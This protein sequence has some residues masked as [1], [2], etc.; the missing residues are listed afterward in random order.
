MSEKLLVLSM[1]ALVTEDLSYLQHKPNYKKLF[2]HAAS[3]GKIC[4]VYPSIT[5][6]AHTAII[7]GC[8]PGKHGV[9]DN[10]ELK[11]HGKPNGQWFIYADKIKTDDLF[12]AAKRAGKT[13][14]SVFWP[15]TGKH[16]AIDWLI[17]ECFPYWMPDVNPQEMFHRLGSS[18]AVIDII[19]RNLYRYPIQDRDISGLQ[20]WNTSDHFLTGCA[21][22]IIR[23]FQPDLLM[24][25]NCYPDSMRHR[26]GL[27]SPRTEEVLDQMDLWLGEL[28]DALEETGTYDQTNFVLVS[29]HGQ[30]DYAR[31]VRLNTKFVRDGL[32]RLTED[33]DVA[34]WK[35]FSKSCGLSA[36]VYLKEPSFFDEAYAYLKR[37]A[38]E[39][40]WGFEKIRTAEEAERDYGLYGDFS[41]ILETDG[42]TS[43][44]DIWTEP[45]CSPIDYSDY[46]LGK[47][48]HG[49]E[50]EKG[51]QPVFVARGPAF[52]P[53]ARIESARIID[54]APTFARILGTEVK[55][56]EGRVLEELLS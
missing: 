44:A 3:A 39:G 28:I 6:P 54:E 29:D 40:V 2:A 53:D 14:A 13:T 7:T 47:A 1:D 51:P 55:D 36:Y 38:E 32:I 17:D 45:I 24:I 11:T 27:F 30:M 12:K 49:Y 37:L 15:V 4:T 8:R 25:H 26:Y 46:R 48:T 23:A 50:P 21:A 19:R 16:P 31:R 52:K 43:F 20:K 35:L 41:F 5:Y 18:P 34:D 56:A 22:G 10:N 33:G 42:Y 9:T